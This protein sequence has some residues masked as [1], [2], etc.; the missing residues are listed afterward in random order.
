MASVLKY[1]NYSKVRE[2]RPDDAECKKLAFKSLFSMPM[3]LTIFV[4]GAMAIPGI[5]QG[6]IMAAVSLIVL[7]VL[8]GIATYT[9]NKQ[10]YKHNSLTY[11]DMVNDYNYLGK[12]LKEKGKI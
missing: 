2:F 10:Y 7:V 1:K 8:V 6:S 9:E 5:I 12:F 4:L 11:D 3:A